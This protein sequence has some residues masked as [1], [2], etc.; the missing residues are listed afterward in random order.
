LV[1]VTMLVSFATL[2]AGASWPN[3]DFIAAT[4]DAVVLLD[5]A[6]IPREL[7]T[8]CMHGV[9][10]FVRQLGPALLASVTT[11]GA[12]LADALA[13]S[14]TAVG[15]LHAHTCDLDHPRSPSATVVVLK[16]NEATLEYLVLSDSVLVL[17]TRAGLRVITDDR[18]D[19]VGRRF[20]LRRDALERGTPEHERAEREFIDALRSL[21]N[22]DGG[23]WMASADPEAAA[24]ALT[25]SVARV[26]ASAAAVLS[27]GATRLVDRFGLATWDDLLA[28]LRDGGPMELLRQ[29]RSAE[30]SDPD[31]VRWR[32]GKIFDDATAAYCHD[33]A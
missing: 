29:V 22:R 5:G 11:D 10:W 17:E 24:R 6:G 26:D 27:D 4:A 33:F 32:R 19:Q 1:V 25:G 16:V 2:P 15:A 13:R 21:R 7:E 20:R 28:T 3:E 8:G 30:A 9:S 23:F 14:I 31:G 12:G 18:G